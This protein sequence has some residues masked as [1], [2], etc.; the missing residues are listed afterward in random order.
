MTLQDGAP[1][2]EWHCDFCG[3]GE[4]DNHVRATMRKAD[5]EMYCAE[6]P[7]VKKPAASPASPAPGAPDIPG[8]PKWCAIHA[9]Y[10]CSC[11]YV[12]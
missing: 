6:N 12:R 4:Y 1:K 9:G 10:F 8:H 5:H 3:Y 11:L 2:K 7:T